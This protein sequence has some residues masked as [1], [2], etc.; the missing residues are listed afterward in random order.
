MKK[1]FSL[2]ACIAVFT[3]MLT[4]C[5]SVPSGHEG[6][7]VNFGGQTDMDKVYGEGLSMGL[8]WLWDDLI[9]YDM[10]EKTL[11]VKFEFND[12]NTMKTPVEISIDFDDSIIE[13]KGQDFNRD[14]QLL[15][16]GIMNDWE[17]R[18][19]WMN[20]DE[21]TAKA[22]LPKMQDMAKEPEE[23]IE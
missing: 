18:M 21:E 20:E 1:F 19:R 7:R 23:E 11:T 8:H 10:R 5:E 22:A 17:F 9:P 16:A 3:F 14:V 12:K 13:D 6:T 15:N 4:S 2:L